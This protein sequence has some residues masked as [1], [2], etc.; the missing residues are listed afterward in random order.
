MASHGLPP[1]PA[2]SPAP[3]TG[4]TA[5]AATSQA[6][7]AAWDP[8]D[9]HRA[10]NATGMPPGLAGARRGSWTTSVPSALVP[11]AA[12]SRA[13]AAVAPPA[14]SASYVSL[15]GLAAASA[16]L[17]VSRAASGANLQALGGWP[18]AP[19]RGPLALKSAS[20]AHLPAA[21]ALAAG[22]EP[23]LPPERLFSGA[24]T[25]Q[26]AAHRQQL[27]ALEA[28][29]AH[30]ALERSMSSLSLHNLG[31][32]AASMFSSTPLTA[33]SLATGTNAV[34]SSAPMS[35]LVWD[36]RIGNESTVQ[37]AGTLVSGQDLLVRQYHGVLTLHQSLRDS[38]TAL[39]VLSTPSA[40][41]A[42]RQWNL[43][44]P[45]QAMVLD[46]T[47]LQAVTELL[48][49]VLVGVVH[50]TIVS[51]S[52]A[53]QPALTHIANAGH[54][55]IIWI[56]SLPA[57]LAAS[58]PGI[59]H[60]AMED[61][62]WSGLPRTAS[63]TY[64][65]DR[66]ASATHLSALAASGGSATHLAGLA[67]GYSPSKLNPAT[68]G[69][70]T[71][72][73]LKTSSSAT[74]LS[75]DGYQDPAA[76]AAANGSSARRSK[77]VPLGP[78]PD[79]EHI[80]LR[81]VSF[82]P[83]YHALHHPAIIDRL[84][85]NYVNAID[86]SLLG[87]ILKS[88]MDP[89]ASLKLYLQAAQECGLLRLHHQGSRCLLRVVAPHLLLQ[90]ASYSPDSVLISGA[91]ANGALARSASAVSL[92]GGTGPVSAAAVPAVTVN[93]YA[94][95][96]STSSP[97]LDDT[98][99]SDADLLP[100]VPLMH[101]FCMARMRYPPPIRTPAIGPL[102]KP[103]FA[104]GDLAPWRKL[105]EYLAD[106][107][108]RGIV[109]LTR[110]GVN[111]DVEVTVRERKCAAQW[112]AIRA[113]YGAFRDV[114]DVPHAGDEAAFYH[115]HPHHHHHQQQHHQQYHAPA[116]AQYHHQHQHHHLY[117]VD[118]QQLQGQYPPV[119]PQLQS[120][121]QQQQQHLPSPPPAAAAA[122][123]QNDASE[124]EDDDAPFTFVVRP[125]TS[126]RNH[127][128]AGPASPANPA[129]PVVASYGKP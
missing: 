126:M 20:L 4:S 120:Q 117:A 13:S 55:R 88:T 58:V 129:S 24:S 114:D 128:S 105:S 50:I 116:Q 7:H 103:M 123:H 86:L 19:A 69:A 92:S 98:P 26:L 12:A 9:G 61:L 43:Q 42:L 76:A 16:V 27:D 77:L 17:P 110:L 49:L 101:A 53:I 124:S 102:L 96:A 5:A 22:L 39:T 119:Q 62:L 127:G 91:T 111:G 36:T 32:G 10:P 118:Q 106:A 65:T 15:A 79:S 28:W 21:A 37:F 93:D 6:F 113:Q 94:M 64:L 41:A 52:A 95:P 83:L 82:G 54:T 1:S 66:A 104:R 125:S 34:A 68:A 70:A 122:A 46:A 35:A 30:E 99:L 40:A 112:P 60:K 57:Q 23:Y 8:F 87:G 63:A 14:K 3:P 75:A 81:L 38:Q 121:P 56:T 72:S 80:P 100:Y 59:Q 48:R 51:D 109:R 25:T 47:D 74:Y 67:A 29:H 89:F 71:G 107:E 85:P 44:L 97:D 31:P 33:P 18:A 84:G 45:A 90:W 108:R 73:P 115:H 11:P 78:P 2:M